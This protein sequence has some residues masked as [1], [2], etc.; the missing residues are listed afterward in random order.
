[1]K[2]EAHAQ[3]YGFSDNMEKMYVV[4]RDATDQIQHQ[5]SLSWSPQPENVQLGFPSA[6]IFK[7]FDSQDSQQ[8]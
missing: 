1:M 4:L 6:N 5:Q 2:K 8:H 3:G 7:T